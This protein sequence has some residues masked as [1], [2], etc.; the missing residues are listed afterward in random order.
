MDCI[1]LNKSEKESLENLK[2]LSS[3]NGLEAYMSDKALY[4]YDSKESKCSD[5]MQLLSSI[6]E[7]EINI[8][9]QSENNR[10]DRGS[11][12]FNI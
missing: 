8:I 1:I 7:Q 4:L 2:L 10:D 3:V 11:Y 12:G 9:L 6:V 5:K